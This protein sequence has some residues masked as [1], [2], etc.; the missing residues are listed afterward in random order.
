MYYVKSDEFSIM[1]AC[2]ISA[3][4]VGVLYKLYLYD[5]ISGAPKGMTE[6]RPLPLGA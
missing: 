6:S 3:K 2:I 5:L 4:L 1:T